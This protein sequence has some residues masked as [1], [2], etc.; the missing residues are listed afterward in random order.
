MK[1]FERIDELH[2]LSKFEPATLSE[3]LKKAFIRAYLRRRADFSDLSV[4]G[5]RKC[6]TPSALRN[7][8]RD[9]HPFWNLFQEQL[10][11]VSMSA[12]EGNPLK[13]HIEFYG[14]LD[15]HCPSSLS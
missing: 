6:K 4:L 8:P 1:A 15:V 3:K 11:A 13:F 14:L 10:I 7:R 2:G 9:L 12:L 5:L